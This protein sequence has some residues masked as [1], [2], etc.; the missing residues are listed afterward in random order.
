M[1]LNR[2]YLIIISLT[3]LVLFFTSIYV[4]VYFASKFESIYW[5]NHLQFL[6]AGAQVATRIANY[7]SQRVRFEGKDIERAM[8]DTLRLIKDTLVLQNESSSYIWI[9][10]YI[11]AAD[12]HQDQVLY[13]SI[14][15]S[16]QKKIQA[17]IGSLNPYLSGE[18]PAR[19]KEFI[20]FS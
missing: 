13:S 6:D 10:R 15:E 8:A 17:K 18:R 4:G 16:E 11:E 3:L 5:K 1:K 14:S 19:N 9:G 12:K 7:Q 2:L 20:V